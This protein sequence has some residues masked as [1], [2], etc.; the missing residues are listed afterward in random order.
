ML[1][2]VK[3]NLDL[4]HD[5]KQLVLR[6]IQTIEFDFAHLQ[7]FGRPIELDGFETE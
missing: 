4:V 7:T 3:H 1:C 5:L 6:D 2:H